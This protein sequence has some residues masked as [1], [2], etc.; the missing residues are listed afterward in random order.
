ME[1][2]LKH[3]LIKDIIDG[4]LDNNDG[5]VKGYHGKLDIRPPYQREFIYG[6]HDRNAVIDTIFKGYPLN[7]MYWCE[8]EDGTFEVLDGQQRT[9]SFCQF[10][11]NE[12]MVILNGRMAGFDNL[13]AVEKEK[14]LNYECMVYWCKGTHDEKL[15]WFE[16]INIAGKTLTKQELRNAVYVGK[17]VTDAKNKFSKRNCAGYN[18]GKQYL[19]GDYTRQDYLETVIGWIAGG[20]DDETIKGYMAT[21]QN[22]P[23]ALEL[24]TY[25]M[26]VIEWVKTLFPNYRNVMKG[27]DWGNLYNSY[28]GNTYDPSVLENKIKNLMLDDEITNKKGI[29]YYV[30][31]GDEKHLNLRAFTEAQKIEMYERQ[32]GICPMCGNHFL[33]EEMEAD[34]IDPWHSGGKTDVDNGQMLCKHCNRIKSGH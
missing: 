20:S 22:D 16:T 27:V 5:G 17:W 13:T 18:L 23:N 14:F 15:A 25:Y 29:Y 3:I 4:Y 28:K 21:H 10:A 30:F 24:W 8:N 11:S 6:E 12:F 33:I 1:I 9:I 32:L 2:Q 19:S 26:S 34:H 7:V 31:D